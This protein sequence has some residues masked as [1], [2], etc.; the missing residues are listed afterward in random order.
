MYS[1]RPS[2]RKRSASRATRSPRFFDTLIWRVT[3]RDISGMITEEKRLSF[4]KFLT[5]L[6]A[7]SFK[8]INTASSARA[9]EL[10][11]RTAR[12]WL[13]A[14][15]DAGLLRLIPAF[16]ETLSRR[17]MLLS[18]DTGLMCHLLGFT[19]PVHNGPTAG[20]SFYRERQGHSV[21]LVLETD[22]KVFAVQMSPYIPGA[23]GLKS[24][25]YFRKKTA[26]C[27][28]GAVISIYP[29]TAVS[30]EDTRSISLW[31]I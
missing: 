4:G 5:F 29:E 17:P 23:A 26:G 1:L 7:E 20:M 8:T 10:P 15:L 22:G 14:A 16:G 24:L 9:A 12:G 28:E 31:S 27:S 19:S 21:D 13:D 30:D 25:A 2:G 3:E 18:C 6:A 11:V